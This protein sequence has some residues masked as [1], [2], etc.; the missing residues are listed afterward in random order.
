M[1]FIRRLNREFFIFHTTVFFVDLLD[2]WKLA[3]NE[4]FQL[5]TS[6]IRPT[7]KKQAHG[8]ENHYRFFNSAD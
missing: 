7:R 5:K 1:I 6:K 4:K 2:G 3:T 8:C